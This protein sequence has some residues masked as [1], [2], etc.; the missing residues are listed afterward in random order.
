MFKL[1]ILDIDGVMTD[2]TKV[3]DTEGKVVA[4]SFYDH[5]FTAIKRFIMEGVCVCFLSGDERVNRRM[6][7]NRNIDYYHNPKG[8]DKSEYLEQ[9]CNDYDCTPEETAYVGD[10]I[11][12]LDI[13][14][15]V[16]YPFCPS[17]AVED[18]LNFCSVNGHVLDTESG[19]GVVKE[20]YTYVYQ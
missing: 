6:C 13:M 3:Y 8:R 16:A 12:D 9:I 17:D 14:N 5:D 19:R 11:Y 20:L 2:G 1:L 18:V 15:L 7:K 4:K 10:D